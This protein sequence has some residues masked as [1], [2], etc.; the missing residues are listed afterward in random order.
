MNNDVVVVIGAGGIGMAIARRQ[1]FGRTILLADFDEELLAGAGGDLK[2]G[3]YTV[4]T[5]RVDVSSRESVRAPADKASEL[6]AVMQVVNTA[7]K[8]P[9]KAPREQILTVDLYGTK[10]GV[11]RCRSLNLGADSA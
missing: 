11:G 8:S 7:G 1:G 4:E 6:G 2:A 10:E 5:Q 9:N 3:S